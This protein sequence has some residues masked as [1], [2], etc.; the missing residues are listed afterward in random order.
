MA[1]VDFQKY[2]DTISWEPEWT[3]TKVL[4]SLD[5]EIVSEVAKA[6]MIF[7]KNKN[8]KGETQIETVIEKET[9]IDMANVIEK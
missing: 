2:F 5:G 9:V 1:F 6:N 7:K 8:K 3:T 4:M